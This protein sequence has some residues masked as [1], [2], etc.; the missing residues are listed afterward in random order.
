MHGLVQGN[1]SFPIPGLDAPAQGS[2]AVVNEAAGKRHTKDGFNNLVVLMK[3]DL[4]EEELA[5]EV[6]KISATM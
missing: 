2:L 4:P 6:E 5:E 3:Q 1:V